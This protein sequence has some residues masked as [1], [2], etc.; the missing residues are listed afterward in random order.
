MTLNSAMT[1]LGRVT[2]ISPEYEG[3]DAPAAIAGPLEQLTESYPRL[4]DYTD[5]LDFLRLTG[6]A[7]I[8]N[9]TFSLGVYGFGGYLVTSFD[10]GLFLDQGHYFRFGEVLYHAHPD[11][12]YVF[13]FD[14]RSAMDAVYVSPIERSDYTFCCASFTELLNAFAVGKLPGLEGC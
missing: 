5:Y 8:H 2:V 10:E 11:P 12:V 3:A 1:S 9:K 13:A 6:G 4:R 7:H 14:L